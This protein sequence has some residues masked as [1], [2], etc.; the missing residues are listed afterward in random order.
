MEFEVFTPKRSGSSKRPS[1]RINRTGVVWINAAATAHIGLK[2]DDNI[3]FLQ[4][5]KTKD[6]YFAKRTNGAFRL[7]GHN[8]SGS[9]TFNNV[10]L[11]SEIFK[12]LNFPTEILKDIDNRKSITIPL[13]KNSIEGG[14]YALLTSGAH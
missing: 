5:K 7:R 9:L 8:K 2:A 11:A 4:E 14:H 6:W 10:S 3:D 1:L 13:A 12:C